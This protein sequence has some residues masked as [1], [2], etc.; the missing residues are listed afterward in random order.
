M[1]FF[2]QKI[3]IILITLIISLPIPINLLNAQSKNIYS[4]DKIN[5]KISD[6]SLYDNEQVIVINKKDRIRLIDTNSK[7]IKRFPGEF[8]KIFYDSKNTFAI[9]NESKFYKLKKRIWKNIKISNNL[10]FENLTI[11]NDVIY[12]VKGGKIESFNASGKRVNNNYL[13]SLDNVNYIGFFDDENFVTHSKN[14]ELNFYYKN[15][16]LEKKTNVKKILFV[17]ENY[18]VVSKE[19]KGI[20][21]L[22]AQDLKQNFKKINFKRDLIKIIISKSGHI[23]GSDGKS[24]YVS[25]FTVDDVFL[26]K[27]NEKS[28]KDKKTYSSKLTATKLF[29]GEDG[30]FKIDEYGSL[31]YWSFR[32][33]KFIPL[34]LKP[35]EMSNPKKSILWAI[36]SLGRIFYYDGKKWKQ[37]KGLAQSISSLGNLTLIVDENKTIRQ[38][39]KAKKKFLKTNIKAEKVFVEDNNNFWIMEKSKLKKCK[40]T[41]TKISSKAVKC[42][43]L[44]GKFQNLKILFDGKVFAISDK[45]RLK[46]FNGNEFINY[47]TKLKSVK[48]I[49]GHKNDLLWFVDQ[50]N[51]IFKNSNKQKKYKISSHFEKVKFVEQDI[52]GDG[53]V[54]LYGQK[55]KKNKYKSSPSS[56]NGGFTYKKNMKRK[57]VNNN[58]SFIDISFGKDGRLWAVS[59]N[60]EAYQYK[61]KTKSFKKYTRTNFPSKDQQYLGLPNGIDIKRI[62][63]DDSGKIWLVK[64]DSKSV[65]YQN[66]H[67]GKFIEK[68]L[69]GTAQNIKDLAIDASNNV[70]IAAGNI[71]KWNKS[72][73]SFQIHIKKNGPFLRV[74]S[75]PT[76]TLWAINDDGKLFELLGGK[77]LKRP[78]KG[79]FTANDVDISINGEVYITSE[80]LTV[81]T[82][83]RSGNGGGGNGGGGNG[84]GGNGGGQPPVTTTQVLKCYLYKYNSDKST[85]E[86]AFDANDIYAEIVSISREGSPWYTSPGCENKNV[87]YGVK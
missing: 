62:T 69:A 50:N 77:L 74:S 52:T 15:K 22:S 42:Y 25:S 10:K 63:S 80:V 18:I 71:Y 6:I 7:K 73:N 70:Y 14:K 30:I 21:L 16:I 65:Y 39:N 31:N 54:I 56:A 48:D 83:V 46:I 20:F 66:K 33:N 49:I 47:H 41:G 86:H 2:I 40:L 12:F 58:V 4:W 35:L 28:K 82:T 87:Y 36:N 51:N 84:G 79:E 45:N 23:W 68:K 72:K 59:E 60:N 32:T 29:S 61:D 55:V 13:N 37:I 85:I 17:D 81:T 5:Y 8:N 1:L 64:K 9:S 53:D 11:F 57:V 19:K 75:G 67:K 44:R 34:Y 78:G 76:G 38:F 24:I 26:N 3:K 43:K 27:K